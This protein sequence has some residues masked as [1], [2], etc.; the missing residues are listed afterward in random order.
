MKAKKAIKR[1][2]KVEA[3]LSVVIDQ[4]ASDEKETL[5]YL[6]TARN[7]VAHAKAGVSKG[8]KSANRK[9]S[10]KTKRKTVRPETRKSPAST[11][12]A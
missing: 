2:D 10:T 3:I 5:E 7:S 12:T 11:K 1:L 8:L 6:D 4:Y 9:A